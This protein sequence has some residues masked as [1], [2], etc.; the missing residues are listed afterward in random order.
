MP[1][2]PD[3]P[4][5]PD[6]PDVDEISDFVQNAYSVAFGFAKWKVSP[7]S[8][9]THLRQDSAESM[10]FRI[11]INLR[12]GIQVWKED[13]WSI[14]DIEDLCLRIWEKVFDKRLSDNNL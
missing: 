3:L 7:K 6:V 11:K 9:L 4:D 10:D 8:S 5:L 1:D 14:T 13:L 12:Y 2:L